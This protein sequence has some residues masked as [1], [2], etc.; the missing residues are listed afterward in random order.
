MALT[1]SYGPDDQVVDLTLPDLGIGLSFENMAHGDARLRCRFCPADLRAAVTARG[2]RYFAHPAA[3]RCPFADDS[4]EYLD[5]AAALTRSS[6]AGGWHTEPEHRAENRVADVLSTAA[7]GCRIAWM[8]QRDRQTPEQAADRSGSYRREG[9]ECVWIA[10][11]DE[12]A[13]WHR[14]HG[15]LVTTP[16]HPGTGR[17]GWTVISGCRKH[18][19]TT[20]D[21]A[22]RGSW[23]D[24]GQPLELDAIAREILR[25]RL[26]P[27]PQHRYGGL[28]WWWV[29]V[30]ERAH[31][32]RRGT[33]VEDVR[34]ERVRSA[35]TR[36]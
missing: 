15:A 3:T 27:Y 22:E 36:R 18:H 34:A 23:A 11:G 28:P 13:A 17:R 10:V 1:A 2:N 9:V 31:A 5:L 30:D 33:G 35:R 4:A 12:D 26:V 8:I 19:V 21:G 20:V 25:G 16:V 24:V 14:P 32:H 29:R 6:R 7:D